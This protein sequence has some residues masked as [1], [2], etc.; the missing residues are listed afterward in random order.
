MAAPPR[1]SEPQEA[2]RQ[3]AT[4]SACVAPRPQHWFV[5][6]FPFSNCSRQDGPGLETSTLA[7]S[8]STSCV[9]LHTLRSFASCHR[10]RNPLAREKGGMLATTAHLIVTEYFALSNHEHRLDA[11][12]M[13]FYCAFNSRATI[14]SF[15]NCR[16]LT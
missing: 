2:P 8:V 10:N 9:V 5:A 4:A 11:F 3:W 12:F 1:R 16:M 7:R 6:T 14:P 15:S 13:P